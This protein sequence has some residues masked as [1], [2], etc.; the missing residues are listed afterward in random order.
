MADLETLNSILDEA[1]GF[2]K[3]IEE[4]EKW[5]RW[6]VLG[7][8]MVAVLDQPHYGERGITL[9]ETGELIGAIGIVPYID[10]FG[11]VAAFDRPADSPATAEVGLFWIVASDHRRRGYAAEAAKALTDYLFGS[12][13]LGRIMA[14]TGINN[15]ASQAVM[16]KIGMTVEQVK[17]AHSSDLFAVGV[18]NNH[19]NSSLD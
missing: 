15:L 11:Q 1:S 7:Y 2:T 18:L 14:T 17:K 10:S 13:M 19:R 9:K 3:P 5:L 12:M 4:R 8:E 6:T 16:R